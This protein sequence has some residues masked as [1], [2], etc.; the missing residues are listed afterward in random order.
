[1][2]CSYPMMGSLTE[3]F[4]S[5]AVS[6]T[7]AVVALLGTIPFA[8]FAVQR[9]PILALCVSLFVRGVGLG[10]I[11]IP[12]IAA[13]YASI[14]KQAIPMATTAINIV[15]RLGGP[16]ATTLLAIFLYSRLRTPSTAPLHAFA[17][18]FWVLCAIH[19][20]AVCAAFCLPAQKDPSVSPGDFQPI[21]A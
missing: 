21:E 2:L 13:A 11:G 8:L 7:G 19:T 15:Q 16:A 12:S 20:L 18:T 10:S 1:M 4:G 14:P 6:S 17:T 3:R 5:R 9:L